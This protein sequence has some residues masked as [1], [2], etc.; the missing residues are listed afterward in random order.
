MQAKDI[1]RY[2]IREY[3]AGFNIY[4]A[5][6][7]NYYGMYHSPFRE[8]KDASMKVDY[9]KNLWID[10]GSNEGGT[11]IDF[12]MRMQNC[13]NGEA[14]KLLEQQIPG[15]FSFHGNNIISPMNQK[16][17]KQAITILNV[18][19]L[20][21]PALL[22]YLAERC[23]NIEIARLHCSEVHYKANDKPYFAI[24][25][26]NDSGGWVLRSSFFKGCTSMDVKTFINVEND[27][28]TCLLF[29]G[30]TDFLSYLTLKKVRVPKHDTIV[31]NS[32]SNIVKAKNMLSEYRTISAF[33]DNDD[34]GKRAVQTLRSFCKEV[35]N[36]SVH[37][38]KH[39]DLN[40]YLCEH[41]GRP[42]IEKPSLTKPFAINKERK[43]GRRL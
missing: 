11:L 42:P 16:E 36:Q 39:K 10:F 17:Q 43:K 1:N 29:E 19:P 8:D 2:P 40:D 12:V 35:Q 26:Q 3:L 28:E 27:K 14:M 5:K 31:L 21:N 24:G 6:E 23:V 34:A 4:P 30:F 33:L 9:D 37:Y 22:G 41:F 7:R 20:S 32:V 13:S 18:T 38:A 15:S 25:F